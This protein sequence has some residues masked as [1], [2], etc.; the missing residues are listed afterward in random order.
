MIGENPRS[1]N[2]NSLCNKPTN[3]LSLS[4]VVRNF[5]RILEE[6]RDVYEPLL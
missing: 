5:D 2:Y 3:Y 1:P 4:Y 6:S